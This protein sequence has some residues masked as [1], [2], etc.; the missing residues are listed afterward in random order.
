MTAQVGQA[1][2]TGRRLPAGPV[3][4]L[5]FV[6]LAASA[7]AV[8]ALG[9]TPA[10]LVSGLAL[11]SAIGQ[12]EALPSVL[13]VTSA[14]QRST[15]LAADGSPIATFYTQ[16]RVN[17]RLDQVAPVMQQAIVAIEDARFFRHGGVDPAGILRAA[18]SDLASGGSAQGASTLTQQYVKNLL[19]DAAR[20]P[21]QRR[22]ASADTISRKLQ[23]ARYAISLSHTMSRTQILQG[24]LNT[25]YFGDGSY[26][27]EAAAQ[28]Y[29]SEPAARLTLPQAALLA[30][31]VQN[32]SAYDPVLHPRAATARRASV[33]ESMA[34]LRLAPA[35][36]LAAA[37]AAPLGLRVTPLPSSGCGGATA[38]SFC[39]WVLASL[40]KDPALGP[41][42]TARQRRLET[43]GLVVRTTLDPR[44]QAAAQQAVQRVPATGRA[45]AA[46]VVVQP[47]TGHVLAMATNRP[48]GTDVGQGQSTVNLATGGASGF[49]AG[50]T[51]KLFTLAAALQQGISPGLLLNAPAAY[52]ATGLTN[53]STGAVF[54]PYTV[55]NAEPHAAG[56][57]PLRQA[58]WESVNTYYLQLEQRTGLCAPARIATA[59]GVTDPGGRPLDPVPSFTLGSTEV[60]PLT[61][62]GAYAAMAAHGVY[63]PASGI[64]ETST[65]DGV[66]TL[67]PPPAC[68]QAVP[69]TVAD[70]VTQVLRGVIDGPDANR[71][72]GNAHLTVPAAGKTGT[73]D[74]FGAAW[75]D[76]YTGGLAAAVWVG[77]PRGASHPLRDLWIGRSYYPRV[78]GGDLPARIWAATM[79]GA[80]DAGAGGPLLGT[81]SPAGHS[82][83]SGRPAG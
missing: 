23:E 47:G 65:P 80:V 25:V 1:T 64:L 74:N 67:A 59:L 40:L 33:L 43:G 63:C 4:W 83:T 6:A 24:Y 26:G 81:D 77:D 35:A 55:A 37:G 17:V 71:T 2:P 34:R 69:A 15:L 57:I 41:D 42:G 12:F 58:T 75:F 27:I 19:L 14:P 10:V 76:G 50:S 9:A 44:V 52:T 62:A 49:Q 32:P 66:R 54:P 3:G 70:T 28:H 56:R 31:L 5:A 82:P 72:G 73:T 53:C 68:R 60:S 29:F 46:V 51:F 20:T 18:A 21:A 61:M 48:F 78:F 38:P 45:A 11:R 8:L 79:Q 39:Q 13:P 7:G 36:D 16:D 30:G 22:A